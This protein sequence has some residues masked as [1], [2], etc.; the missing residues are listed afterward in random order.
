MNITASLVLYQNPEEELRALL[1]ALEGSTADVRLT[2]VDNS[3]TQALA[4]LFAAHDYHWSGHNLGFGAAH[5]LAFDRIGTSDMHLI[6]NPDITFGPDVIATLADFM[7]G[8]PDVACIAP[9]VFYR[10]GSLQR[11]CKLLPTP[12]NLF[13]RRFCPPLA[14][15]LDR[16][17]EMRAFDYGHR[18]DLPCASGCFMA[19]RTERLRQAGGF[20]TRYFMYM[21]DIDLSRRLA[22]T[23][24]VVFLPEARI[25]H[26]FAK[27]S[28]RNRK[29]MLAHIQSAVR[30]FNKWGWIFDRQR[31]KANAQARQAIQR[32][33][34]G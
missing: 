29:L 8:H 7:A 14:E 6:L 18:I 1:H 24:R 30:Y 10:D 32:Y 31:N 12:L 21:E 16:D 20:D 27:A 26:G 19:V 22:Q 13:S 3:P 15:R 17:Y 23:G 25:E 34:A 28:Y 9:K 5:N 33:P 4:P 11:L 2:V